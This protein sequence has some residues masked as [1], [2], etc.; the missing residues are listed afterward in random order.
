MRRPLRLALFVVAAAFV[1]VA[2]GILVPRP[3]LSPTRAIEEDTPLRTVLLLS[4]PIHT[5]IAL[6][7]DPDVVARFAAMAADG[8]PIDA[9]REAVRRSR[10][11]AKVEVSGPVPLDRMAELAQ[12]GAEYVSIAQLTQAVTPIEMTFELASDV[13]P[14]TGA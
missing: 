12:T 1:A 6:P 8:L 13:A 5:D 10:G 14:Q 2:A 9:V 4:N 11:R 3:L 7:A